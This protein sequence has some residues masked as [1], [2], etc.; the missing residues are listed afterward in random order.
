MASKVIYLSGD[1]SVEGNCLIQAMRQKV[2]SHAHAVCIFTLGGFYVV[3]L[4]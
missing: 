3:E 4:T 1:G 2:Y